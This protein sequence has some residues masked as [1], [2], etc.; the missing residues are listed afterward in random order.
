MVMGRIAAAGLALLGLSV[1]SG[2]AAAQTKPFKQA[3]FPCGAGIAQI[4]SGLLHKAAFRRTDV[5]A[6]NLSIQFLGH[7]SFLVRSPG[8]VKVV[9][10]Y[11]DNYRADVVPDIAT[12]NIQRG[13]HSSYNV[14]PGVT[15][16]L[17][18]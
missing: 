6:G 14:E 3:R 17:R 10:D 4:S 18:G 16:V 13:N 5:P 8:G 15:H 11:N 7:A 9:T 1:I 12:M 2:G